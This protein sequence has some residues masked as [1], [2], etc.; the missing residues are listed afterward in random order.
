MHRAPFGA[1]VQRWMDWWKVMEV[2]FGLLGG[3]GLGLGWLL[4]GP[5]PSLRPYLDPTVHPVVEMLLLAAWIT[6]LVVAERGPG[7][8]NSVWEASFVAVLVPM[9]LAFGGS[10]TSLVILGPVLL[11][12]S[13]DNVVRQWAIEAKLVRP[14]VA[15]TVLGVAVLATANLARHWAEASTGGWLLLTAWGQTALTVIW[16]LGSR[17][18]FASGG[19]LP[20]V[21]AAR[22]QLTVQAVFIL[23]ALLLTALLAWSGR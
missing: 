12:V 21:S 7:L 8:A 13:G 18:V 16:A 22:A 6:W 2:F 1:R 9:A 15:W 10:V 20:R 4:F 5:D 11:L 3:A 19:L 17:E 23:M 14:W